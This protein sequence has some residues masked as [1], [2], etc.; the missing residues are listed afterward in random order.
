MRKVIIVF[1]L[2]IAINL[3]LGYSQE[4]SVPEIDVQ[5]GEVFEPNSDE[6]GVIEAVELE[7]R[8]DDKS[9][10]WDTEVEVGGQSFDID[11]EERIS[12][13]VAIVEASTD[14]PLELFEG[15]IDLFV[16]ANEQLRLTSITL[17]GDK[18]FQN[19]KP[20][21]E[22][23]TGVV[24][25]LHP[26][27]QT[28]VEHPDN[29]NDL[30]YT[31]YEISDAS[32]L[33]ETYTFTTCG[34]EGRLGPDQSDCN[35]DYSGTSLEGDVNVVQNQGIQEWE[36]P[37]DGR[38]NVT[39]V[40]A[41][42]GGPEGGL[43]AEITVELDLQ[44]GDTLR[45]V[46]AQ[47]GDLFENTFTAGSGGS[48]VTRVTDDG[49]KMFDGE[50]IEPI[51]VAGGGAGATRA[52]QNQD[53]RLTECAGD[54]EQDGTGEAGSGGCGG[55][56]GSYDISGYHYVGAGG[57]LTQRGQHDD[58]GDEVFVGFSFVEGAEGG[59]LDEP[60]QSEG[61][62][63]S[64][65]GSGMDIYDRAGGGGGYSG[66]GS[67]RGSTWAS[68][69][70]GGSYI[71][72]DPRY[73]SEIVNQEV[74]NTGQ[75]FVEIE[76]EGNPDQIIGT[77][78]A[79]S[80]DIASVEWSDREN[81]KNYSWAVEVCEPGSQNCV[82][83]TSM[84]EFE[85]DIGGPEIELNSEEI[86]GEHAF[87]AYGEIEFGRDYDEVD[88]T[89]QMNLS[90]DQY[91]SEDGD[92]SPVYQQIGERT[93]EFEQ[94]VE[95]DECPSEN[96]NGEFSFDV[97]EYIDVD[98]SI[99]DN[100]IGGDTDELTGQIP[101]RP[102][103]VN[104]QTPLD[105]SLELDREVELGVLID[106]PEDDTI[107]E[108]RFVDDVTGETIE[109]YQD[110]DQGSY[111]ATWSDLD[112]GTYEWKVI[113][114]DPYESQES[115]LREFQRV[116]SAIYRIQKNIEHEYSSLIVDQGGN[117]FLFVEATI[118]TDSREFTTYLEGDNIDAEFVSNGQSSKTYEVEPSNPERL[119]IRVSGTEVG[120]QEL[121]IITSDDSVDV[122][123][124]ETFPVYVRKSVT[125]GQP[126]PGL[127]SFY[128]LLI[129]LSSATLYFL[130][131]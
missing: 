120:E 80:E 25:T 39:A 114:S 118:Q 127:T 41:E 72:S 105:G 77:D 121:R 10:P 54:A 81:G 116:I 75:G 8:H 48:F 113:A 20:A 49:E 78:T 33:G 87:R 22:T 70:G 40:G 101:N 65:G 102:P 90:D 7:F 79:D 12:S 15:E 130:L 31:F 32:E 36:V 82:L 44:K 24:E 73:D 91:L 69:G 21:Y 5:G 63:G 106:D 47:I 55:D 45:I 109:T 108:V 123:T 58:R 23:G 119:H 110:G 28:S 68:G 57:G 37:F 97:L 14:N 124:T 9:P 103:I 61:G 30:E 52:N 117:A 13:D 89:F 34:R 107:E 93:V 94:R 18:R 112:L 122:N 85:V 64:G 100:P 74:S 11:S 38:Y 62:F 111:S 92:F 96:C 88:D 86:E 4:T 83:G 42:G 35:S 129:L 53:A 104:L 84:N 50:E 125:E 76:I 16:D 126:L 3:S 46:S 2:L 67:A 128:M 1:C 60:D 29:L 131:L 56:G 66:G 71:S 95:P 19:V 6:M 51:L 98:V 27:L 43:G 99:T 59:D 17:F 26:N 115:E